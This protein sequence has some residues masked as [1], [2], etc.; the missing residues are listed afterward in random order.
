LHRLTQLSI[1]EILKELKSM[2]ELIAECA[3]I[4]A[5]RQETQAVIIAE[6]REVHKAY[7]DDD[8]RRSSTKVDEIK[9]EDLIADTEIA[10]HRQPRGYIKRTPRH[11]SP[12][13]SRR[14]GPHR[15]KTKE[16]DFVEYLFIASAHS[17]ILLFTSKGRVYWLKSMNCR[18]R[19]RPPAAKLFRV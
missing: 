17:Y 15:A 14:Q 9:L 13:I 1:D 3:K 16:E 8:A 5:K 4:L 19:R 2:R 18:R 6:L 12:P 10:D 11:V 7:G